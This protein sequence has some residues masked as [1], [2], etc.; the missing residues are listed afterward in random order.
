MLVLVV[1]LLVA[2]DDDRVGGAEAAA[3]DGAVA[4]DAVD[5]VGVC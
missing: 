2:L 3:V 5:G 1:A 4:A